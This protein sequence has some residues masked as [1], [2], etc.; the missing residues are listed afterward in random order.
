MHKSNFPGLG[1]HSR[2][3][4]CGSPGKVFNIC[5]ATDFTRKET[6][7]AYQVTLPRAE[8]RSE[9]SMAGTSDK[10]EAVYTNR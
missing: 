6:G 7:A 10:G 9:R 3:V 5:S 1:S 8:Y 4:V 2:Y